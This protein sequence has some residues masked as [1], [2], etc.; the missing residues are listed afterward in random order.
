[1]GMA[2]AQLRLMYLNAYR[3]DLEYKMQLI[4]E[5]KMN[6]S[7]TCTDLL[8]VGTDLSSDD[9][10]VKQLEARKERLNMM[11]KKLDMQMQQ[12]QQKL[13]MINNEYNSCESMLKENIGRSFKY[14]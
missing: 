6:L 14:A 13:Q 11:E 10:I 8:N 3:L 5:A 2:T 7:K 1:M 4:T 9:P 12:Y